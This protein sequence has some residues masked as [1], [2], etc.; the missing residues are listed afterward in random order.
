ML[1]AVINHSNICDA[2]LQEIVFFSTVTKHEKWHHCYDANK[3][4]WNVHKRLILWCSLLQKIQNGVA[5]SG[6]C[7][8]SGSKQHSLCLGCFTVFSI[9]IFVALLFCS[10]SVPK[11]ETQQRE[12]AGPQMVSF[13][14]PHENVILHENV[15]LFQLNYPIETSPLDSAL[16]LQ[17]NVRNVPW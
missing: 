13:V 11:A 17:E 10:C 7:F 9:R 3:G 6:A 1:L 4:A 8:Y 16:V 2:V 15:V 14:F 12:C 5:V